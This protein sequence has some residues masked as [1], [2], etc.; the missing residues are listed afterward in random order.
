M[1]SSNFQDVQANV[2]QALV[3][4][5][6][7]VGQ[8]AN[9]DLPFL[10]ASNSAVAPLLD[11]QR[12]RLLGLVNDLTKATTSGSDAIA[13]KLSDLD[14]VEDKW[15]NLV[16]VFDKL[17]EKA[18]VCLDERTGL[19]KKPSFSQQE[20]VNASRNAPVQSKLSRALLEKPQLHFAT[21]PNNHETHPFRPLLQVK[22]HALI[23][24]E[25]SLEL[26][27]SGDGVQR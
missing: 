7:C 22:P 10:C 25:K 11:R 18:D 20:H 2:Q 23:P 9:E 16:D 6:R 17:L 14:A 26:F 27:S 8:I 13:P 12:S 5:T 3:D 24:L 4:T 21:L 15:S 1:D 19:I